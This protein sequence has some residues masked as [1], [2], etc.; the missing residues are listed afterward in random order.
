MHTSRLLLLE[1]VRTHGDLVLRDIADELGWTVQRAGMSVLRARRSGL[2]RRT[3]A[4]YGLT[5][6]GLER[7]AWIRNGGHHE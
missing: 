7:L 5:T 2:L 3:P 4:G 1:L 6:R